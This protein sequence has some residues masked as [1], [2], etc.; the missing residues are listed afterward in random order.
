MNDLNNTSVSFSASEYARL[1]T[2][3]HALNQ[4]CYF[5]DESG[6]DLSSSDITPILFN[7]SLELKSILSL[8]PVPDSGIRNDLESL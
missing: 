6:L 7:I 3:S 8:L 4:F 1:L 5:L 2:L